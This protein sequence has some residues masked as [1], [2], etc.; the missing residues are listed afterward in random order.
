MRRFVI[1]DIR[2]ELSLLRKLLDRIG[3]TEDDHLIF[4]GSYLGPGSDSKGVLEFLIQLQK[5]RPKNLT[6]LMGCYEYVFAKALEETT[7]MEILGTWDKMKGSRVFESYASEGERI[8]IANPLHAIQ[9]GTD[10]SY[11]AEKTGIPRDKKELWVRIPMM[12]PQAHV[13]F[14]QANTGQWYEDDEFPFVC[15]HAGGYPAIKNMQS[16]EDVVFVNSNWWEQ[17]ALCV[18]GKTVIF[19]HVAFKVPLRRPGKLG[20]DLGCGVGG[21][22]CCFEM[23]SDSFTEVAA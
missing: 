9:P 4:L 7:S 6:F 18:P 5:S 16:Y 22:L 23:V 20:L 1:P 11:I 8:R 17:D 3:P 14:L 21:K 12:I 10:L 2:G 19:S 13:R 15:T